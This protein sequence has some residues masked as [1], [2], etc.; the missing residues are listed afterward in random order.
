MRLRLNFLVSPSAAVPMRSISLDTC[1]E[2]SLLRRTS[3]RMFY[4]TDPCRNNRASIPCLTACRMALWD[5]GRSRLAGKWGSGLP[6]LACTVPR[7]SSTTPV[8]R[9]DNGLQVSRR[10]SKDD[11]DGS[12]RCVAA[13]K[14]QRARSSRSG[15]AV[16]SAVLLH[17]CG[18]TP[19]M[20]EPLPCK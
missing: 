2:T 16:L 14:P 1:S 3:R 19:W 13:V 10:A 5:S 9:C 8:W 11:E 4:R 6:A 17:S 12:A 18:E 15:H 7:S 20:G